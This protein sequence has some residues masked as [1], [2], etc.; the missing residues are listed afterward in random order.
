MTHDEARD[1]MKVFTTSECMFQCDKIGIRK[2][3]KGDENAIREQNMLALF[4][5]WLRV[6]GIFFEVDKALDILKKFKDR[7]GSEDIP[8]IEPLTIEP[9]ESA[10]LPEHLFTELSKPNTETLLFYVSQ[11]RFDPLYEVLEPFNGFAQVKSRQ[12]VQR[13]IRWLRERQCR[14]AHE[15]DAHL[16][17]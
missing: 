17:Q 9:W 10:L 7:S 15:Y 6:M 16:R 1:R 12:C 3:K 8:F 11:R 13:I 4:G 5:R 2:L 14:L